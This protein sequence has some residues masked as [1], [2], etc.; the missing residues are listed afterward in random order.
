MLK[1][2]KSYQ[3][4]AKPPLPAG[5]H[6]EHSKRLHPVLRSHDE[7]KDFQHHQLAVISLLL[8]ATGYLASEAIYY[9]LNL[10]TR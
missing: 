10:K 9:I 6:I 3:P 5:Q 2:F 7:L 1:D 4:A 8:T